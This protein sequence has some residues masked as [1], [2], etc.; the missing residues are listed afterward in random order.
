MYGMK[1]RLKTIQ[2]GRL[3]DKIWKLA[4]S[5]DGRVFASGSYG[6]RIT[7]YDAQA[8]DA[9]K[10]FP[11]SSSVSSVSFS[12]KG[13]QIAYST[14]FA[15]HV[16]DWQQERIV[17]TYD[18]HIGYVKS[19]DFSSHQSTIASAS[20]D[21]TIKLWQGG[22]VIPHHDDMPAGILSV[23]FSADGERIITGSRDETVMIWD[24]HTG[25]FVESFQGRHDG[26]AIYAMALS[27][28]SSL[29]VSH[30][31]LD[32]RLWDYHNP[33]LFGTATSHKSYRDM[34]FS[35]DGS[36]IFAKFGS[37]FADTWEVCLSPP[38]LR[39]LE[40]EE[41]PLEQSYHL[42]ENEDWILDSDGRRACWLP[43][44][45]RGRD[46]DCF[47]SKVVIAGIFRRFTILD[48]C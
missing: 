13:D 22:S 21:K 37:P 33:N 32:L 17:T 41:I 27:P 10:M 4:S 15:V 39:L 42:S 5:M 28:T 16:L 38:G 19:V 9:L 7:I 36:R 14:K 23:C 48:F 2:A 20:V 45:N 11:V 12:P 3:G 34:R 25:E 47:G 35:P 6:G 29:V 26:D 44:Q 1:T 46:L 18:G 24:A 43:S 30:R 40:E 8:F 31:G